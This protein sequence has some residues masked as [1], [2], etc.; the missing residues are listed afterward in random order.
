[1]AGEKFRLIVQ[2]Y[3]CPILAG[4]VLTPQLQNAEPNQGHAL[5]ALKNNGQSMYNFT[6]SSPPPKPRLVGH[7]HQTIG[8]RH[9]EGL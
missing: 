7:R 8:R 2:N 3:I 9:G 1:M 5:A 6:A 4:A